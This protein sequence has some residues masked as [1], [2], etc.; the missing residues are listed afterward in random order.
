M[1]AL[2]GE[3]W[4]SLMD[5]LAGV[6]LRIA[7]TAYPKASWWVVAQFEPTGLEL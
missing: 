6:K 4:N 7:R 1:V 5:K 2:Q 3:N